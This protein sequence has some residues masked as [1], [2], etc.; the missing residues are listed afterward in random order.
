[1]SINGASLPLTI[2]RPGQRARLTFTGTASQQ[3][4]VQMTGN[5]LGSVSVSLLKPDTSTLTSTTSSAANFNLAT[6]TLPTTGTYTVLINPS[7][8]NTGSLTVACDQAECAHEQAHHGIC[9]PDF[10]PQ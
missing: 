3:V 2:P 8:T 1:L 6:Q 9:P 5:T 4:T 10:R 7:G